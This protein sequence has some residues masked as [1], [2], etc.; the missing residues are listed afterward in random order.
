MKIENLKTIESLDNFL[1]GNHEVAFSVFG[2]KTERYHFVCKTLIKFSSI[3][4]SKKDKGKVIRYLLKMTEY[5]RQQMTRLIKK[6]DTE[7]V[8][9]QAW[10][11]TQFTLLA[12]ELWSPP[13]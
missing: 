11:S 8:N 12:Q 2:N 13:P 5:S 10:G 4:L 6:Y 7:Q 9:Q 1:Q 3:T